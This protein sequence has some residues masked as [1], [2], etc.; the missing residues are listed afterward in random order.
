MSHRLALAGLFFLTL[1]AAGGV[2]RGDQ[3]PVVTLVPA[4][5]PS[6]T[7]VQVSVCG[8]IYVVHP[9]YPEFS[10]SIDGT[11]KAK[12]NGARGCGNSV[13][14]F[15]FGP[16]TAGAGAPAQMITIDGP[17]GKHTIRVEA[18]TPNAPPQ[19]A[20]ATFTITSST[21]L[22]LGAAPA[23]QPA[24]PGLQRAVG[25]IAQ[26]RVR[27][28]PLPGGSGDPFPDAQVE[29]QLTGSAT[30][31]GLYLRGDATP[32]GGQALQTLREAFL[33]N[34]VVELWYQPVQNQPAGVILEIV[35]RR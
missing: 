1:I 15:G 2:A 17:S 29:V 26:L 7:H 6:G 33:Q 22:P 5:G 9:P 31:Y 4:Q 13:N 32:A 24:G 8:F 18:R 14:I 3:P 35:L 12:P 10:V 30:L 28:A 20:E 16:S 27:P 25:T 19:I 21:P 11:V 23:Q 34:I